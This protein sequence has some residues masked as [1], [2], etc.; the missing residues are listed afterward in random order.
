MGPFGDIKGPSLPAD[1]AAALELDWISLSA[2][3][4]TLCSN[5]DWTDPQTH[6][7]SICQLL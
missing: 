1:I 5:P 4:G 7:S 6:L 3:L 2:H